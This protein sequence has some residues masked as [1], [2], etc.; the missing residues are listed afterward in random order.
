[1]NANMP[2]TIEGARIKLFYSYSHRDECHRDRM[3]IALAH[4]RNDNR[5]DDWHDAKILSGQSI[6]RELRKHMDRADIVAFLLTPHFL[7]SPECMREWHYVKSRALDHNKPIRIPIV[8]RPCAWTDL[9]E[10]DDIKALPKDGHAITLFDDPDTAWH[11][12]YLGLKDVIDNLN[13]TFTPKSTFLDELE[14]TDFPGTND[15]ISLSDLFVFPRLTHVD[16]QNESEYAAPKRIDDMSELLKYAQ[17][18]IHG[19]EKSGRTALARSLQMDL[20]DKRIQHF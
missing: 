9:L 19:D 17:V 4:L 18:L 1:M 8:V 10:N 2:E 6:S 5:I 13:S 20:I 16:V 7:A 12:V 3:E 14:Y 15:P 11:E